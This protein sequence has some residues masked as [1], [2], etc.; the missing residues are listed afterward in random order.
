MNI[1]FRL[2]LLS[3][4]I[5]PLAKAKCSL[6][7]MDIAEHADIHNNYSSIINWDG[8]CVRVG[9]HM[10]QRIHH[11]ARSTTWHAALCKSRLDTPTPSIG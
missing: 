3:C 11:V 7:A 2:N 8:V 6:N 9:R 1:P 10:K 4:K 5:V